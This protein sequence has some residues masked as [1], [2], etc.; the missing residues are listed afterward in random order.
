MEPRSRR[1]VIGI[2]HDSN[3]QN[4]LNFQDGDPEDF[5]VQDTEFA[6]KRLFV[7]RFFRIGEYLLNYRGN[8]R[9]DNNSDTVYMFE[10][11][12]PEGI[13]IDATSRLDCMGRYINDI[14]PFNVQNCHPI[15]QLNEK[16]D[17]R[18]CFFAT[19]N[20][21]TGH[22]LRY[23]YKTN[24][25][26]WRKPSFFSEPKGETQ[27]VVK[28][29]KKKKAPGE[30]PVGTQSHDPSKD[31]G[32]QQNTTSSQNEK[33][34]GESVPEKCVETQ[35]E[36]GIDEMGSEEHESIPDLGSIPNVDSGE[37][38]EKGKTSRQDR[39]FDSRRIDAADNAVEL[40]LS[41]QHC[42]NPIQQDDQ[43]MTYTNLFSEDGISSKISFR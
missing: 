15:K 26:P 42:Q 20:I 16:K 22:E 7:K 5:F 8:R 17:V 4:P 34:I 28:A 38:I 35:I 33:D 27:S 43:T 37:N 21:D 18:F 14:D 11:G 24:Y 39:E 9:D 13:V 41:I 30:K 25:A 29:R 40:N 36:V 19:K 10:V 2:L 3:R 31:Y 1:K 6:G 23:D 12:K 32:D